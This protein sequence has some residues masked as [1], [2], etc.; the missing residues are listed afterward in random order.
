M[1]QVR[2]ETAQAGI[3]RCTGRFAGL[4]VGMALWLLSPAAEAASTRVCVYNSG[5]A[6]IQ[7]AAAYKSEVMGWTIH[8]WFDLPPGKR[9]SCAWVR[10]AGSSSD[11]YYFAVWQLDD[12]GKGAFVA[13]DAV[14][15]QRVTGGGHFTGGTYVLRPR[16]TVRNPRDPGAT[17]TACVLNG[18]NRDHNQRVNRGPCRADEVLSLFTAKIYT[19]TS[20]GG[21]FDTYRYDV[22]I[23]SDRNA[24]RFAAA[25][26]Y[27]PT[28][29][30]PAAGD[31]APK[32][33]LAPAPALTSELTAVLKKIADGEIDSHLST[34]KDNALAYG[35]GFSVADEI[36]AICSGTFP[37]SYR[38]LRDQML[39][40]YAW[41]RVAYDVIDAPRER[42]QTQAGSGEM[43]A[44]MLGHVAG[45]VMETVALRDMLHGRN[46]GASVV[47]WA[48]GCN[49][50]VAKR[51][52]GNL[53]A[54]GNFST[55]PYPLS[56]FQKK[57]VREERTAG[58]TDF[59]CF[60]DDNPSD[61]R[62][63]YQ[64]AVQ[65]TPI[66]A[67]AF[68]LWVPQILKQARGPS[69]Q[70]PQRWELPRPGCSA[71]PDPSFSL[72]TR[73]VVPKANPA[74]TAGRSKP[75]RVVSYYF[76]TLLPASLTPDSKPIPPELLAEI[77]AALIKFESIEV[78][79]AEIMASQNQEIAT[80]RKGGWKW[81]WRRTYSPFSWKLRHDLF[82]R[83]AKNRA[84]NG[85]RLSEL[86][87][88]IQWTHK[89]GV[90]DY[91]GNREYNP[92]FKE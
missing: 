57:F 54:I 55:P 24:A 40:I 19:P 82:V 92:H 78:S 15:T 41:Y 42:R 85:T 50:D 88:R 44:A 11:E 17:F 73:H 2:R 36:S 58:S 23:A 9:N 74:F 32:P 86:L 59:H 90:P 52:F 62:E 63:Y 16:P 31:S 75:E 14:E 80:M 22:H 26:L 1:G 61:V 79:D 18:G 5:N 45:K 66:T 27:K 35:L 6:H 7:V 67:S 83:G 64:V 60:Y 12:S 47:A 69:Y 3:D 49:T 43:T 33:A 89:F 48:G 39:Q 30:R 91:W 21:F 28:T 87:E 81:D 72:Q 51:L 53:A 71:S 56:S 68:L 76:D 46:Y 4:S 70:T 34:P 38:T 10:A 25:D 29:S 84:I 65:Y 37:D 8:G 13:V 20:G 77:R